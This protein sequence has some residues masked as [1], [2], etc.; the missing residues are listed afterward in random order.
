VKVLITGGAGF[1]GRRL[2]HKLVARG[3]LKGTDG[4]DQAIDGVAFELCDLPIELL[5]GAAKP[6]ALQA[7]EFHHELMM[8]RSTPERGA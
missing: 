2:A 5:G 4:R 1:L 8:A 6:Q 3:S 7:R